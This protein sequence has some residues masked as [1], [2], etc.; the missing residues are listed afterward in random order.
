MKLIIQIPCYNEESTLPGTLHDLPREIAGI[1]EIEVLVVDD[2]STDKTAEVAQAHGVRHIVRLGRNRGLA[3]AFV[4][5]LEASL[6]A[7]A[8]IIVNTD[9]DNQYR[10]IVGFQMCLIGLVAD[11][12]GFNRKILE[13]TLYRVRKLEIEKGE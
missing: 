4:R 13:E 10:G 6:V 7:G 12:I 1:D 8:D 9:A 11:L 2:G 5:G 3:N